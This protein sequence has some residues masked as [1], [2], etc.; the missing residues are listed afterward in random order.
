MAYLPTVGFAVGLCPGIVIQEIVTVL[1]PDS[2]AIGVKGLMRIDWEL[3][4][5]SC[6]VLNVSR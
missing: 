3:V 4:R 2:Q 5:G 1:T 6:A